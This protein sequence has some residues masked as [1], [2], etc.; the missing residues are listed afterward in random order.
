MYLSHVTDKK[1]ANARELQLN[2]ELMT[3]LY[4][5]ISQESLITLASH[6]DYEKALDEKDTFTIYKIINETHRIG[7]SKTAII[8]LRKFLTLSMEN[9]T[10]QIYM[11]ELKELEKTTLG[12]FGSDKFPDMIPI[13][14][15]VAAIYISGLDQDLFE[16]K[17]ED[18][19]KEHPNMR[20][21]DNIWNIIG[22]FHKYY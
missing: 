20:L 10:H 19:F 16:Y 3:L 21:C 13:S 18:F 6:R 15:L 5:R 22:E 14:T 1:I 17:I 2:D 12:N 9:K 8:K 11:H 4:S 7:S